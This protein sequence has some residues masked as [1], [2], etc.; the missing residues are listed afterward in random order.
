VHYS[1]FNYNSFLPIGRHIFAQNS[2][3]RCQVAACCLYKEFHA[4]LNDVSINRYRHI[5]VSFVSAYVG[6][7]EGGGGALPL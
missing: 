2:L 3:E 6:A 4:D 1:L 5:E 7:L